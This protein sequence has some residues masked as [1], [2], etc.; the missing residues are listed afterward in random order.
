M[1]LLK[2]TLAHMFAD[3]PK[4]RLQAKRSGNNIKTMSIRQLKNKLKNE[5]TTKN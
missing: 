4:T 2:Q 1:N 5:K 3:K